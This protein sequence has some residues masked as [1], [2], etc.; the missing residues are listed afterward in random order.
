TYPMQR[1]R[2]MVTDSGLDTVITDGRFTF[3]GVEAIPVP[4][5]PLPPS[6]L[7]DRPAAPPDL[8]PRNLAYVIYTSG[9]TGRPKGVA[10]TH[11][12]VVNNLADVNDRYRVR[13]GD[14]LL[15]LAALSF[16][17]SVYEVFGT[18][19]AGA[20]L[21]LPDATEEADPVAWWELVT[22]HRATL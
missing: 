9:S 4:A 1:L 12:G 7:D 21:I 8:D 14:R 11:A 17:M 18:L 16:D 15:G 20:T 10:V 6:H 2:H 13:P 22:R 19:G 5:G 3:A